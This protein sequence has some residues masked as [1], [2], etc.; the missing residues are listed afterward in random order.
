MDAATL[1]KYVGRAKKIAHTLSWVNLRNEMRQAGATNEEVMYVAS[2][3]N[4]G[5]AKEAS[6]M[7][8]ITA[9]DLPRK[10]ATVLLCNF[11]TGD[12]PYMEYDSF[13]RTIIVNGRLL[14]G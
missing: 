8:P 2:F 6:V 9:I 12:V 11:E 5:S 7:N 14:N 10:S 13:R 4:K 3:I 1:N